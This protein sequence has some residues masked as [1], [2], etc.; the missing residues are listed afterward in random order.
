MIKKNFKFTMIFTLII[1]IVFI[2]INSTAMANDS[3]TNLDNSNTVHPSDI[4]IPDK[5]K[6]DLVS[7]KITVEEFLAKYP[8]VSKMKENDKKSILNKNSILNKQSNMNISYSTPS[9]Y[10]A[11]KNSFEFVYGYYGGSQMWFEGNDDFIAQTGCG[12][13]AAC[14]VMA[15]HARNFGRPLLYPYP[16]YNYYYFCEDIWNMF[17]GYME[18]P[19]LLGGMERGVIG[20]ANVR[21]VSGYGYSDVD[22]WS[23]TSSTFTNLVDLIKKSIDGNNPVLV[24]IGP[25]YGFNDYV[26]KFE[27]HWVTV[28]SYKYQDGKYYISFSSWGECYEFP[29]E[30]GDLVKNRLFVDAVAFYK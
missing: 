5:D 9:I 8:E 3:K 23:S 26:T 13:V 7:K 29:V 2:S 25:I 19:T 22:C 27:D 21:G 1:L 18:G 6:L 17:Y 16:S 20:Y 28:T 30:L 12:A 15:Y 14:N 24:L 10:N 4:F 11:L